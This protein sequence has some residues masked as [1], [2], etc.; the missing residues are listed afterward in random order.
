MSIDEGSDLVNGESARLGDPIQLRRCGCRTDVRI[1]TAARHSDHVCRQGPAI[2]GI[3][4]VELVNRRFDAIDQF[5]IGG[6]EVR[7]SGS[8]PVVA[9]A[10][11]PRWS[12]LKVPR[13]CKVLADQ[14]GTNHLTIYRFE[15]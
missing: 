15:A 12:R 7:T 9:I 5:L 1:E 10:A 13:L 4:F 2:A 6:A 3:F 11:G 14:D 8:S